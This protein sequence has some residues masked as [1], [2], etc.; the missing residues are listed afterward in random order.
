VVGKIGTATATTNEIIASI[1]MEENKKYNVEHI[2][3]R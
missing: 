1:R 2:P 3:K